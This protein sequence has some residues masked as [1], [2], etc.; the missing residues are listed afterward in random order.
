MESWISGIGTKPVR[1]FN[2]TNILSYHAIRRKNSK[3]L[4]PSDNR[5]WFRM[6]IVREQKNCASCFYH[7]CYCQYH[8]NGRDYTGYE[9]YKPSDWVNEVVGKKY[10]H[11]GKIFLCT[12]YDPLAGF[13]MTNE[14]NSDDI[15][16]VSERAIGKIFHRIYHE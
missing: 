6:Y 11:D 16:N 13:W 2:T 14:A 9:V 3:L 5:R 8:L 4:I 10:K 1:E 7:K 12:G 15:R